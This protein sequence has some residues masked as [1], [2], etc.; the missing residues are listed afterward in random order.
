M[1]KNKKIIRAVTLG[2]AC[3]LSLNTTVFASEIFDADNNNRTNLFVVTEVN[4][5]HSLEERDTVVAE[6]SNFILYVNKMDLS[7]KVYDKKADFYYS[8]ND[9]NTEN[10]NENWRNYVNSPVTIKSFTTNLGINQETIFDNKD[11]NFNYTAIEN[12][13]KG[14][15][16]FGASL[17]SL[18]FTVVLEEDG[19]VFEILDESIVEEQ[20][21]TIVAE[22]K[23]EVADVDLES[24]TVL[25]RA[26]ITS[27]QNVQPFDLQSIQ[28]YPFFGAVK[29]GEQNGYTF[30]PEK[31]GALIRYN[32]NYSGIS[33]PHEMYFY[34]EDSV[35]PYVGSQDYF[36]TENIFGVFPIYGVIHGIDQTGFLNIVESGAEE[37]K[38]VSYPA[39]LFTEYYF[40]T[41]EYIYN[42]K[43]T[44]KLSDWQ[45]V[46]SKMPE[47]KHIDIKEHIVFVN[48]DTADYVGLAKTYQSYLVEKGMLTKNEIESIPLKLDIPMGA[49]KKGIF[50]DKFVPTTTTDDVVEMYDYFNE[51][52]VK[53]VLF[54]LWGGVIKS[55]MTGKFNDNSKIN[56]KI[57]GDYT[58]KEMS[59][60]V[61]SNGGQTFIETDLTHTYGNLNANKYIQRKY[62]KTYATYDDGSFKF[63]FLNI[64]GINK[65]SEQIDKLIEKNNLTGAYIDITNMYTHYGKETTETRKQMMEVTYAKNKE[66]HDSGVKTVASYASDIYLSVLDYA[67]EVFVETTSYQF[68]TDTVPFYQ[69]VLSGYL[70]MI[71]NSL[72]VHGYSDEDILKLIEYNIYPK[73]Y[74]MDATYDEISDTDIANKMILPATFDYIK[75]ECLETY[76]QVN[77]V[78]GEVINEEI[79]NHEVIAKNVVAVTYSNNKKIIINYSNTDFN[80]EGTNVSKKGCVVIG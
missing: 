47:R 69:I 53:N 9:I 22:I 31:T 1:F 16:K 26:K 60:Y 18:S 30:V 49:T 23:E 28:L 63:N 46:T 34:G 71:S 27:K 8:S 14:D 38:L 15:L 72:N 19:V 13:F 2:I 58:F 48:G 73:F 65:M 52:G 35:F 67:D 36:V 78:L 54:D 43:F 37:A 51:N 44:Q 61:V 4:K 42:N 57:Q 68:V 50:W 17:I 32:E 80:Y 56:K 74:V 79:I 20:T 25:E 59:E 75:E 76:N 41:V 66:I 77:N 12:G 33:N 5:I 62:D 70:P 40:T 24:L 45:T 3:V 10:L 55:Q 64:A 21:E 7:I 29:Y 39:G 6:N 11:S